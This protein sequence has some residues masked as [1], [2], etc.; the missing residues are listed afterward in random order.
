MEHS[1]N[2]RDFIK[3]AAIGTAVSSLPK[4][5]VCGKA[6]SKKD[7]PNFIF[8]LVDD[9]GWTGLSTFMDENTAQS[10]SDFY[11]TPRLAKFASESMRFSNAYAPSPMC[12]P[13][14]ASFLTGKS[15]AMLH[16]TNPGRADRQPKKQQVIPPQHINYLPAGEVTI[17]EILK[18]QNYATAHFGKWHLSG[19]GPGDHGF[20]QHD[21]NTSNGGPG[22]YTDPNP[23][24]IFG[25]TKRANAFMDEQVK[26][27]KPFY[28]QLSH[29]A[30]H[31]PYQALEKTEETFSD[32]EKGSRHNNVTYAAMTKDLDTSIGMVLDEVDKLRIA[33]NTYIIVMSD[34]GAGNPRNP[35][36]N[37][38]LNKGK[39]TL[40]EGGI[41]VPL[42]IRGVNIKPNS[43]CKSNVIGYDL[44]P[45]LCEL[46]NA[47]SGPEDLEGVS[48]VPL[49]HEKPEAFS[50]ANELVFHFP[51]YGKG[52]TQVP[53][54]A[55]LSGKWKLTRWYETGDVKLF[56]L[57]ED[58]GEKNDLSKK[59]PEKAAELNTKL[60]AYL[61][62]VNAQL[63]TKNPDYD[64]VEAKAEIRQ[65]RTN[66]KRQ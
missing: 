38:P 47:G 17:A 34:N 51:H 4:S 37:T 58:I 23:K 31:G 15:P 27:Q 42:I 52:A 45:T 36:E 7:K 3:I 56:D 30:V 20:D 43:F 33:N 41:R 24:D 62:R 64:P 60:T 12:T 1:M 46:A 22:T 19:Q 59:S 2:R 21:G 55:I 50:R 61:K 10:K 32:R 8:I 13:S 44:F 28:L 9:M 49:L 65:K 16:I 57:S 66:R 29:Y 48:I 11:N 14:R 63:P 53:Q 40:W 25:I 6:I 39:A 26:E 35:D 5:L 18:K 54:S